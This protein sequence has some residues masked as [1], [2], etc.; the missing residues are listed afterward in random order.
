VNE[1]DRY[2]LDK[3]RE[4]GKENIEPIPGQLSFFPAEKSYFLNRKEEKNKSLSS[5]DDVIKN[6][7]YTVGELSDLQT[8]SEEMGE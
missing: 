5:F 6:A 1:R 4:V 7:G 3:F 8:P 2:W